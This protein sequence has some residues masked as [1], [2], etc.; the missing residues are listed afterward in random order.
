MFQKD[1]GTGMITMSENGNWPIETLINSEQGFA[2]CLVV[3]LPHE[4]WTIS[5]KFCL[6]F[7]LRVPISG[8]KETARMNVTV[9][10]TFARHVATPSAPRKRSIDELG[11]ATV[12][13]T[14]TKKQRKQRTADWVAS[15]SNVVPPQTLPHV[16]LTERGNMVPLP[17]RPG[18]SEYGDTEYGDT[19]DEEDCYT[20]GAAALRE[21]D[22]RGVSI[23][24]DG[25]ETN[26]EDH[27]AIGA[28]A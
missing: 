10:G 23:H 2:M 24:H 19:T 4:K 12:D 7:V 8:K 16:A 14:D 20:I 17:H 15:T 25:D 3:V 26:E 27:R 22:G 9:A 6:R 28:A 18:D 1:L 21:R 11:S 13:A 5:G